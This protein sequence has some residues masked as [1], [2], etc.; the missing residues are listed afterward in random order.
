M[1]Q[2]IDQMNSSRY[3]DRVLKLES[4]S[5]KPLPISVRS[6]KNKKS[7]EYTLNQFNQSSEETIMVNGDQSQIQ[8]SNKHA[9]NQFDESLHTDSAHFADA[10]KKPEHVILNEFANLTSASVSLDASPLGAKKFLE[11]MN[12]T[13][14]GSLGK[15]NSKEPKRIKDE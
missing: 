13:H 4:T 8:S 11:K 1:S 15:S 2:T 14:I 3:I 12:R 7:G 10:S 5:Y 6:K 9:I